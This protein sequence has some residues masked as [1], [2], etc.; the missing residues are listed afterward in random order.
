MWTNDAEYELKSY[1]QM[2]KQITKNRQ[3]INQQKVTPS[4]EYWLY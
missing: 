4:V 3:N 1:V 2:P